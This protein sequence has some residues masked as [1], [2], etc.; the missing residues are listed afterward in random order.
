MIQRADER[1]Q[2]SA[3]AKNQRP[4]KPTDVSVHKRMTS[5]FVRDALDDLAHQ[6][7]FVEYNYSGRAMQP[8]DAVRKLSSDKK[9]K[10]IS[11]PPALLHPS[12]YASSNLLYGCPHDLPYGD[13][14]YKEGEAPPREVLFGA[15]LCGCLM[16]TLSEN[17]ARPALL[18]WKHKHNEMLV[19][20]VDAPLG[21]LEAE[22]GDLSRQGSAFEEHW[23]GDDVNDIRVQRRE[24]FAYMRRRGMSNF[25]TFLV[26]GKYHVIREG[27][28]PLL[29]LRRPHGGYET[30]WCVNALSAAPDTEHEQP[31]SPCLL[32][33]VGLT[34]Q[35][36]I[37]S[38]KTIFMTGASSTLQTGKTFTSNRNWLDLL[39]QTG[40]APIALGILQNMCEKEYWDEESTVATPRVERDLQYEMEEDEIDMQLPGGKWVRFV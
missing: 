19:V 32:K 11:M 20:V 3:I 25:P 21:E 30:E 34:S 24:A 15:T 8:L 9:L 37:W 29:R 33:Q 39:A 38:A 5:T 26:S 18:Y 12:K 27:V 10:G 35:G 16:M 31:T 4:C 23:L 40:I 36:K 1:S 6:Q 7:N 14:E 28:L 2:P 22:L 17:E 13:V